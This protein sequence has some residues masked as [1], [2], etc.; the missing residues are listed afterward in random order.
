MVI[1]G[2]AVMLI[3]MLTIEESFC[4][5]VN[6]ELNLEASAQSQNP[7]VANLLSPWTMRSGMINKTIFVL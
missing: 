2:V 7:F 3:L 5:G 6:S 1:V 4:R